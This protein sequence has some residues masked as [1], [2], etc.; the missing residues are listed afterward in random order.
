MSWKITAKADNEAEILLYDII[1]GYD[2]NWE[3][4]GAKNLI[5]KIKALGD[6]R[7]ITLRINSAGG[8]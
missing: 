4:Q 2:E 6:V 7:N 5:N 1:G 3:Y 8:D